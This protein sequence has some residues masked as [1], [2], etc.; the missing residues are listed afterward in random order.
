MARFMVPGALLVAFTATSLMS[1][2]STINARDLYLEK[3]PED[4]Q[5]TPAPHHLGL[6]YTELL[7]DPAT[8]VV[9][10]VDPATVFH[11]GDC[12]AI[13]FTP[14]RNGTLYVLNHGS[15][16]DWQLLIPDPQKPDASGV[17]KAGATVRVP[18][19]YCFRLDEKPG[20]ET[21][22]LAVTERAEDVTEMRDRLSGFASRQAADPPNI[23]G[24]RAEVEAWQR[25]A[26]RDLVI[27]KLPPSES[28]PGP[29]KAV[30]AV[31]SSA[32]VANRLVI[33]IK[34]RHE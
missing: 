20:I 19:N 6:R 5:A 24:V 15:D 30:Y 28:A 22:L 8:K 21:L 16:G 9:R 33:E 27:E 26:G 3:D 18:S 12:I 13:D 34:I 1:Q 7:V 31:T 10:E 23:K 14:N 25:L 2:N 17:V 4:S 29:A 11:E 32:G